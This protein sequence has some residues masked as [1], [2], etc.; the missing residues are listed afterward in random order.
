M[1]EEE[2]EAYSAN[3]N[4]F[5][6]EQWEALKKV[7]DACEKYTQEA[8]VR[9]GTQQFEKKAEKRERKKESHRFAKKKHWIPL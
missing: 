7:K 9:M 2:L 6:P 4:N 3:P 1:S 8:Q 5:T